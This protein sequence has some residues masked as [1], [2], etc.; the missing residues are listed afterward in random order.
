LLGA[1]AREAANDFGAV[2]AAAFFLAAASISRGQIVFDGDA[3]P[4]HPE[5]PIFAA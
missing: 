3:D 5:L 1:G 2:L 4:L